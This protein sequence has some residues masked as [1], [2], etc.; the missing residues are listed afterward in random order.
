VLVRRLP[1]LSYV[2]RTGFHGKPAVGTAAEQQDGLIGTLGEANRSDTFDHSLGKRVA[3]G[4]KFD[5]FHDAQIFVREQ[6]AELASHLVQAPSYGARGHLQQ[7]SDV[8]GREPI[9]IKEGDG[10]PQTRRE[11]TDRRQ[12]PMCSRVVLG[13][14][15]NICDKRQIGLPITHPAPSLIPRNAAHPRAESLGV[16][17]LVETLEGGDES[18]LRQILIIRTIPQSGDQDGGDSILEATDEPA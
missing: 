3:A 16:T 14:A 13:W 1:Y 6:L 4:R 5:L 18:V 10:L 12:H 11:V 2:A 7:R 17:Q 8:V 9:D 15:W